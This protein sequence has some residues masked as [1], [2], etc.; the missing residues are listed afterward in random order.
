M[1]G[2]HD[3]RS[4][5]DLSVDSNVNFLL[6]AIESFVLKHRKIQEEEESHAKLFGLPGQAER[7]IRADE[8]ELEQKRVT[9]K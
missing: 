8:E 6:L 7:G 1:G 2:D 3:E 5:S 9:G 4:V